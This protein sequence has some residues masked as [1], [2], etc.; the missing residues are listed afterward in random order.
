M[1]ATQGPAAAL[2]ALMASR[3]DDESGLTTLEWLLITAAVAAVAAIAVV[4]V[5]DTVE[6]QAEQ[7]TSHPAT[8][9]AARLMALDVEEDSKL[10][11][12]AVFDTW[13]EWEHHFRQRCARITITHGADNVRVAANQFNGPTGAQ[14]FATATNADHTPP[15]ATKPQAH[16]S[17]NGS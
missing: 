13:A 1:D 2:L 17:V 16:C 9:A 3:R 5:R 4:L 8:H 14:G 10:A 15:S 6:T 11:D 12:P 7:I